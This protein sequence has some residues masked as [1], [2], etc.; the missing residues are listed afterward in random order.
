MRW[1]T[2]LLQHGASLWKD[3]R[4]L[5]TSPYVRLR[6]SLSLI[7]LTLGACA[8]ATSDQSGLDERDPFDGD[9]GAGEGNPDAPIG[10][11]DGGEVPVTDAA[12]EPDASP[13]CSDQTV[14]LL[15]NP[16]FDNGLGAWAQTSSGGY[17][18][19]MNESETGISAHSGVMVG[20][21]SGY[22]N[23]LDS[24]SQSIA[25]PADASNVTVRGQR[26]FTTDDLPGPY[27]KTWLD[28]TDP[29]GTQ[30]EQLAQWSNVDATSA[31]VA[32]SFQLAGNY[33]GQTIKVRLRSDT[34][35][36]YP[37]WFFYDTVRLEVT[38]CQ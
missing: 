18:L 10:H 25:I 13:Q 19:I 29:A 22:N 2:L 26:W 5:A 32:F 38:T 37:S 8:T 27:D 15:H 17:P 21:L 33:Q 4:R 35:D 28:V 24:L 20:W 36:S 12:P 11:P 23:A 7:C 3:S 34:D 16:N 6:S 30:L 9:A 14:N 1:L 31:W